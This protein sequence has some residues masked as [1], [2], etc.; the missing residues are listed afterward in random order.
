MNFNLVFVFIFVFA[1]A[2]GQVIRWPTEI[3]SDKTKH[4][5]KTVWSTRELHEI[6]FWIWETSLMLWSGA[7]E[8]QPRVQVCVPGS[9]YSIEKNSS[10][11]HDEMCKAR[12]ET[13]LGARESESESESECD[14][15]S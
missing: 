8:L 15:K 7:L 1:L 5:E 9:R 3:T 2:T 6:W 13:A 4:S 14:S 11:Q 10:M 12:R